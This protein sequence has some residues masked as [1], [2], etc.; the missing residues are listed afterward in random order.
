M[1]EDIEARLAALEAIRDIQKLRQDYASAAD[2]KY[3]VDR[4]RMDKADLDSAARRQAD[5]FT[6]DAI[7]RGGQFGG[8][9]IG[10]DALFAFFRQSPWRLTFHQYSSVSI[11]IEGHVAK[12]VWRLI[13]IGVRET[14]GATMLLTG[15]TVE[16]YRKDDGAPWLIESFAFERLHAITLSSQADALR[17]LIPL[18]ET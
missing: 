8:D 7:W 12:G 13:E 2:E 9:I 5:C 11:D 6:A 18:G 3:H 4:R 10:R 14:D 17:C 16:S 15:R 1:A